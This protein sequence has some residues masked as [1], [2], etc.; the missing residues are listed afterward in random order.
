MKKSR[1]L[2]LTL[3]LATTALF[4]GGCREHYP[5]AFAI[6]G[7]NIE[8]S[9]PKPMEG[10]YYSNWDPYAA[11]ITITPVED[12]NPLQHQHILVA[13][14]TD[15]DGKPLPNRRVEWMLP[16]NCVGTIVEVDASGWRSTRGHKVTNNFAVSHTNNFEHTL[17]RGTA[18][19]SDDVHLKPGQT[20]CVITSAVE[21]TTHIIAYA[22]GIYDWTKHKVFAKKHWLDAGAK[23]PPPATNPIGTTHSFTTAVTKADG[24]PLPN[25]TVT[26][27]ITGGP[28]GYFTQ[29]RKATASVKTNAKGTATV[30]LA[31]TKPKEGVNTIAID[32]ARPPTAKTEA[33]RIATGKTNKRWIGPRITISKTAPAR[34]LVG[35]KVPYSITVCN[36]GKAAAENVVVTD[37]LP[38]GIKYVSS[39]P[40]ASVKGGTLTWKLGTLAPGACKK[41]GVTMQATQTGT[42]VNRVGVTARHGLS[43]K[44]QAT[45]RVTQPALTLTKTAPAKAAVCDPI[46]YTMIVKNTGT[47]PATNVKLTDTLPGGITYQ[48]S[49]QVT[50]N[51]G[52]LA[53]GASKKVEFAVS[54]KTAG[55]Y[56][57]TAVVTGDRGLKATAAA[58]TVVTAPKLAITKTGPKTRLLRPTG[59]VVTY[60]IVVKNVGKAAAKPTV[61]VDTLPAG[62]R[63]LKASAG[64]THSAG[65]VTWNLGTFAAGASRKLSVSVAPTKLGVI[66]NTVTASACCTSATAKAS[67]LI[68]GIPA[69]L[70]ECVDSTDPVEVGT[71]TTYTITVTNQGWGPLTNVKVGCVVPAGLKVVRTTGGKVSGKNVSFPAVKS[72]GSKGVATFKVVVKGVKGGDQR[73]KVSLT[74]DQTKTPVT[75]TESTNVFSE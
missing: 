3:L 46:T 2:V 11:K 40:R 37:T 12:T 26:Y 73:F 74:S 31:Q 1:W 13:T 42:F 8:R 68:K 63:F 20:W 39:A 16:D 14:V 32:V 7:G 66:T 54:T 69:V 27:K 49:K 41:L 71:Q 52:T 25:Y 33:F 15:K 58:T 55:T 62:T 34:A 48:G 35:D 9:H 44:A 22:P 45:T 10:G 70:L 18:D 28:A 5:H 4:V 47:A 38:K 36:P 23:F 60:D 67:T 61:V 56:K 21:G 53:P 75:E 64:G 24:T 17:T 59:A 29:S 30:T 57:N 51:L 19:T 43:A 50:A 72:L 65:K 6:A